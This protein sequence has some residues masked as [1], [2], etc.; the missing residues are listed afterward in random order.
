MVKRP[1]PSNGMEEPDFLLELLTYDCP[2][3]GGKRTAGLE[4]G[5]FA[6]KYLG[7]TCFHS[8]RSMSNIAT[9]FVYV[10]MAHT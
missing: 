4:N 1:C 5:Q 6:E 2:I 3:T 8:L 9:R 10:S 7:K